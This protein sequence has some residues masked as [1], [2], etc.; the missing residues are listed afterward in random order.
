MKLKLLSAACLLAM[1]SQAQAISPTNIGSAIKIYG[2]GASAQQATIAGIFSNM[3]DTSNTAFPIS[4]YVVTGDS[5]YT[6]RA[7]K[8]KSTV[9]GLGGQVVFFS[10][11]ANGGSGNGVYP[12]AKSTDPATSTLRTATNVLLN[13]IT[14]PAACTGTAAPYSCGP[15]ALTAVH[16]DFGVSDVEP[17]MFKF[18][19]NKP[20][21]F[22]SESLSDEDL[23]QL[24]TK[25]QNQVI[26][27]V[28]VNKVLYSAL[29]TAQATTGRPSIPRSFISSLL[30]G[31]VNDPTVGQGWQMLLGSAATGQ[32]NLGRR[33]AG[34]GTQA[35]ANAYFLGY[36][37]APSANLSPI[38][39]GNNDAGKLEVNMGSGTTNVK[40][41]L[42]TKNNLTTPQYA[43]GFISRENNGP[44]ETSAD[45][46]EYDHVS[47][48]GVEPTRDNV[49]VGKYDFV[50]EQ[51]M[52]WNNTYLDSFRTGVTAADLKLFLGDFRI[53]SGN[54]VVIDTLS[55]TVA[56]GTAAIANSQSVPPYVYADTATDAQGLANAKFVSRATKSTNT[57][58]PLLWAK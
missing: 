18:D 51:T 56:G 21:A 52:Q 19:E 12:I 23:S 3:C 11:N 28:A 16:S 20:S 26:M 55:S 30:A 5:N 4:T 2:S 41:F 45:R 42:T 25:S 15:A 31:N 37:C 9:A 13:Q 33:V 57:C 10:Y 44:S 38:N 6:A 35:A 22:S 1:G 24:D 17:A 46:K 29:Q 39:D 27:G 40:Q 8:L 36:G 14:N 53:R 48:D 47:I 34:S 58:A 43:L 54:P 49:K 50:V 7:C 32:V